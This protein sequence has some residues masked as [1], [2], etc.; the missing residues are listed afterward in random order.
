LAAAQLAAVLQA[1]SLAII[2][3]RNSVLSAKIC[4]NEKEK[5]FLAECAVIRESR[6]ESQDKGLNVLAMEYD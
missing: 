4:E 2:F 3:Q 5:K 6:R 1:A